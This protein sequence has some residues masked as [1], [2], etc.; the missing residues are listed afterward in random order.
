MKLE[1]AIDKRHSIR[2]FEDK[3]ISKSV[4]TKLIKDATKAPSAKNEQPWKFYVVLSK[5]KRKQ[6]IELCKKIQEDLSSEINRLEPKIKLTA[7]KFYNNMGNAP[8][9]I[10]L[11]RKKISSPCYK[12]SNDL[13]GIAGAVE[14]LMLSAWIKSWNLLCWELQKL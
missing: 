8:C 2:E 3:S 5:D 14:N 11:F 13:I 7:L 9:I 12:Y 1:E 4:I 10:F 6:I